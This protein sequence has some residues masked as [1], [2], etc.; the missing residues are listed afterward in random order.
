MDRR[1]ADKVAT[2]TMLYRV[3]RQMEARLRL[4]PTVMAA[5]ILPI[6]FS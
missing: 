4:P 1:W 6:I 5:S 3:G 2:G